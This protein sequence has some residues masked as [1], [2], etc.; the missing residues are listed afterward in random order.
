[1]IPG[2]RGYRLETHAEVADLK[3][4]HYI[5]DWTHGPPQKAGTTKS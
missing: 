1:M 2:A 4:G 5:K 3:I